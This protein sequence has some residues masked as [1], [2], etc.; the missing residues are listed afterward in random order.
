MRGEIRGDKA[1]TPAL[2]ERETEVAL[3]MAHT[4]EGN[5]HHHEH[6]GWGCFRLTIS[7]NARVES[8]V[9]LVEEPLP[10]DLR[11]SVKPDFLP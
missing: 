6:R 8:F 5:K 10:S 11:I 4:A 9:V 7:P 1:L 3:T 2:S